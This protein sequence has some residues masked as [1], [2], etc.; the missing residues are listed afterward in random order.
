MRTRIQE[1]NLTISDLIRFPAWE[2]ALNEEDIQGQNEKTLRPYLIPP[3]LDRVKGYFVVRAR[4]TLASGAS[5]IGFLKPL[6][7][8][9]D[10]LIQPLLPY[11]LNPVIVTNQGHVPFCY[12][13][14]KPDEATILENYKRLGYKAEYVFPISFMADIEVHNSVSEGVLEGFLYFEQGL[15]NFFKLKLSDVKYVK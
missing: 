2:Y 15:Q 4:F 11:D 14:F 13:I 12:G 7:Q 9:E 1:N 8:S 10:E 3:P 6:Q 5:L